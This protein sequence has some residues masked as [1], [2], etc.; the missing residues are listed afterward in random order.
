MHVFYNIGIF[1][2]TVGVHLYALFNLKAKQGIKGRRNLFKELPN[3]KEKDVYWFHCASLGEFDQ[4]LPLMSVIRESHPEAFILVTFFSPSGMRYY[5]KREHPADYVCYIPFDSPA[6][7]RKFVGHFNPK[8]SFF[9]KYEF[10]SNHIFEAKK[11]GSKVY[12]VSGIFRPDHRFFKWYG[13][14]FR[15]TLESFDWLFVQNQES[16]ELLNGIGIQNVSITGDSRFDKVIQTKENLTRNPIIQDFCKEDKVFIVG[17][18]WPKDEEILLPIVN[19]IEAKVII[20]PHNIG[21]KQINAITGQMKRPFA[22]FSESKSFTNEEVLILDTIGHLSSAYAFGDV[23]YVGGGFSGNLH[24]ILEPAV[25]GMGVIFGPKHQRFP[26]ASQFISSGFGF[27]VS[28]SD[29]LK[30]RMN[31]ILENKD[32]ID[33]KAEDFV[34]A[35]KGASRMIF[36]KITSK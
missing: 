2:L 31:Y 8:M 34:D 16:V 33:K 11:N 24:N 32:I 3:V 13:G 27:D 35:N 12:N 10:W 4:G 21:K 30:H 14:F 18:C 17:S 6:K 26:E 23:A 25:F 20:A 1:F 7:A 9:I 5:H 19:S 15:Q 36:D 28:T 29:E 22:R